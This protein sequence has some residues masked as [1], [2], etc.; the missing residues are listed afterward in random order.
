MLDVLVPV[1][2]RNLDLVHDCIL[3]L[4]GH[5]DVPVRLLVIVDGGTA[6]DLLPLQN[7]LQGVE[8]PWRLL[9]ETP[10]VGLNAILREGLKDSRAKLTAIIGPETRLQDH[11]WFGK[12]RQVFDRDPIAGIADFAPNTKSTTHYPIRRAHNRHPMEGCRF[13]VVQTA[14]AQKTQPYG[15]VDPIVHW[16]RMVHAQGGSAW[17]IPSVR[18]SIVEH[19]NHEL[20]CTPLGR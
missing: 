10:A 3:D 17:H 2:F 6:D 7:I 4:L 13:A 20:H 18:Y 14:Y 11:Q 8:S 5:T 9:H 15:D 1:P 12:V 16:S 19:Q